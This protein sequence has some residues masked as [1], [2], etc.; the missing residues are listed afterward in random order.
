MSIESNNFVVANDPVYHVIKRLIDLVGATCGLILASPAM[1]A[2]ALLIKFTSKGPVFFKQKRPGRGGR[3]F[4]CYKFRTMIVDAE[5]VLAR[6]PAMRAK[7]EENFKLKHD[8]RITKIGKLL[9]KTSLDELPQLINILNGTMSIIGPRPLLMSQMSHYGDALHQLLTV[10]PGLGGYWQ[11]YG[12]SDT[13]HE[14]RIQYDLH[15]VNNRSLIL[16]LKL[17]FMTVIVVF[18]G[19][20]AY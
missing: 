5:A 16:D 19:N 7:F 13:S 1:V 11:T 3:I 9:R 8:I 15:Y 12:R 2:I 18:K 10:K 20:G 17:I 6:D 4:D 14:A